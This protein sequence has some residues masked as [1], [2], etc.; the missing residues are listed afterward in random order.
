MAD[1]CKSNSWFELYIPDCSRFCILYLS[2][3]RMWRDVKTSLEET[4]SWCSSS[5]KKAVSEDDGNSCV[6]CLIR[7]VLKSYIYQK[8]NQKNRNENANILQ[9][10]LLWIKD[11]WVGTHHFLPACIWLCTETGISLLVLQS[12]AE[13]EFVV[14]RGCYVWKK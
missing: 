12:L 6:G 8:V 4:K 2:G 3:L 14:F 5:L 13:K 1:I 7:S 10:T 11:G 9:K